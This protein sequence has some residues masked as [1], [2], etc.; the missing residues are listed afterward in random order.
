MTAIKPKSNQN[1][2]GLK[3]L[4]GAGALLALYAALTPK[5]PLTPAAKAERYIMFQKGTMAGL[6]TGKIKITN[7]R[8]PMVDYTYYQSHQLPNVHAALDDIKRTY[9]K[10]IQA[11]EAVTHVPFDLIVAMI[12]IESGG[13]PN[14][15]SGANA[16]GLMQL[17][18]D[19]A[20]FTVALENIKKRLSNYEKDWLRETLGNRLDSGILKMRDLGTEVKYGGIIKNRFITKSDLFDPKLNILIGSI[21]LGILLDEHKEADGGYRLDKVVVRYNM[22][23]NAMKKGALMTGSPNQV[24]ARLDDQRKAEPSAYIKKLVGKNGLLTLV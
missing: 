13:N 9:G 1:Q 23:Y 12:F 18:P 10:T 15:V 7:L 3:V 21:F 19:T 2:T 22:G 24:V 16:V 11:V 5:D 4:L 20:V 6:P 8:V 17:L 14:A